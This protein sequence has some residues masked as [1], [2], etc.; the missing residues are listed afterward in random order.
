MVEVHE[1]VALLMLA[2]V[3]SWLILVAVRYG[4]LGFG[5]DL[6]AA[7]CLVTF[8]AVTAPLLPEG[9]NL[10]NLLPDR[11]WLRLAEAQRRGSWDL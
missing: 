1:L 11:F 7:T 10:P 4:W 5:V 8:G 2:L 3:L 9:W 6:V